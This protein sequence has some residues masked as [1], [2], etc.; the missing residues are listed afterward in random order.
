[1]ESTSQPAGKTDGSWLRR[2]LPGIGVALLLALVWAVYSP[3]IHFDLLSWDD[4]INLQNNPHLTGISSESVKWMFTDLTYQQRYQPLAWLTWFSIYEIQGLDPF[5]YH[6]IVVLLHVFSTLLVFLIAVRLF[7][8]R[9]PWALLAAALWS[10]HPMRVETTVWAV[11]LLYVQALFFFLLSYLSYLKANDAGSSAAGANRWRW[12]S[13]LAF[14]FSLFTFPLAF[15]FVAVLVATDIY[16]LRRLPEIPREWKSESAKRVWIE[17]APYVVLTLLAVWL[18]VMSRMS[19]TAVFMAPVPL[20]SFGIG[21]RVMQAF[22]TWAYYLWRP[23]W[24]VDLKTVPTA[25]I[26]FEPFSGV[27]LL[28]AVVVIGGTW[29]TF[30]Q[31]QRWPALWMVWL[32]HL[33]LLVPML[34]LSE[35]PHMTSDRYSLMVSIG[36]A[37]VVAAVWGAWR[38]KTKLRGVPEVVALVLVTVLTVMSVRQVPFW[39]NNFSFFNGMLEQLGEHPF[40]FNPLWRLGM[41]HHE[42]GQWDEGDVYLTKAMDLRPGDVTRR[43]WLADRQVDRGRTTA[44]WENYQKI[45][46][47]NPKMPGIH[48]R[49]GH[50]LMETGRFE[51]AAK[52]F[53][54]ELE[55][56]PPSMEVHIPLFMAT[57]RSGQMTKAA[58]QYRFIIT[59]YQVPE[60]EQVR[61]LLAIAEGHAARGSFDKAIA[62]AGPLPARALQLRLK[63]LANEIATKVKAWE[64]ARG[65]AQPK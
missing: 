24:P 22:Y 52:E 40:R 54:A 47:V 9:W 43:L 34:G 13:V 49:L 33:C 14:A 48:F 8:G 41:A 44:A 11:E 62:I 60:P 58:E 6:L 37:L 25:L 32:T 15:G 2:A 31:R 42:V 46:K 3:A 36:W 35:H 7:K 30:R 59:H 53:T 45:L 61:C 19:A 38:E 12:A 23:L 63:E 18:N 55:V 10:L 56:S 51:E 29:L 21:P 28:S 26:E 16:L 17:K 50:L 39:A 57:A 27:F 5:G 65:Q 20:E 64:A 1:M 4:D